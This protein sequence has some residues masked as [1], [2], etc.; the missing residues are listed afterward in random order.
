MSKAGF[1]GY[2]TSTDITLI[3][4]LLLPA[5]RI[6]FNVAQLQLLAWE[7]RYKYLESYKYINVDVSAKSSAT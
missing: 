5:S 2:L 6:A 7:W 3:L 4:S 1:S